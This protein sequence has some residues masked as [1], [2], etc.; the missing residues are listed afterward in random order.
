MSAKQGSGIAV[1]IA[2][3]GPPMRNPLLKGI[4]CVCLLGL[5][6]P[7]W[8][9]ISSETDYQRIEIRR[10]PINYVFG[11]NLAAADVNSLDNNVFAF[12]IFGDYFATPNFSLGL[13]LDYWNDSLSDQDRS[14]EVDDLALGAHGRFFFPD[15]PQG[16]RPFV[17]GGLAIHRLQVEVDNRSPN[18]LLL[19]DRF[20]EY[21]RNTRDVA[22]ELGTDVGAGF[23]YR[24]QTSMDMLAEVRY[25]RILDRNVD[26]DQINYSVALSYVM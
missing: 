3:G 8:S 20:V 5:A 11:I 16:F 17:L 22:G 9:Q 13:T 18:A 24:V 6:G 25:R 19:N 2:Q 1:F 7:G 4:A 21:E 12:G 23:M 26:L 15:L 14:I 10:T